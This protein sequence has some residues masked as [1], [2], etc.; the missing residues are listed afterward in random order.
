MRKDNTPG[1]TLQALEYHKQR[2]LL[3]AASYQ[4]L[5]Q[6]DRAQLVLDCGTY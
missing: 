6:P 2:G 4:R 5:G 3:L 1:G